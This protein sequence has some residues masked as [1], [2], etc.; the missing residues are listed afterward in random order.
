MQG[1]FILLTSAKNE[2]QYISAA[3]Q[4]VLCQSVHPVA[5][6]I[7]DDGSTDNT[8]QIISRYASEHHFIRLHSKKNNGQRNFGSKV[9]AINFVYEMAKQLD[10]DFIGIQD[11]DIAPEQSDFYENILGKLEG[12]P[13]LGIAGGYIYERHNGIWQPR[14]SNSIDSVAGGVQMFRRD[15]YEQIGGY[16]PL[17]FGGED[18]LVQLDA[19]MAG[20]KVSAFAEYPIYHYRPTSSADGRW[21]GI[22][23]SGL[24][25]A[26]F[27]SHPVFELFKCARRIM[28]SPF[29]IGSVI[30]YSGF[31]WWYISKRG[32]LLPT[33]KVAYLRKEQIAKIFNWWGNLLEDR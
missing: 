12:N 11:A 30:R 3:I 15:C 32:C 13:K 28:E 6:F 14:K 31:I 10:F 8:A 23:R 26:S 2:E 33:E 18:W 9:K 7:V 27:S 21:R 16:K 20:W 4:S 1:K 22:F 29:L 5:W 17:H 25:D 24:M 19:K